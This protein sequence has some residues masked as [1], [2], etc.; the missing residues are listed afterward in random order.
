MVVGLSGGFSGT[1]GVNPKHRLLSYPSTHKCYRSAGP[2]LLLDYFTGVIMGGQVCSLSGYLTR[3]QD[4][5]F[6]VVTDDYLK[7]GTPAFAGGR[8]PVPRIYQRG[9]RQIPHSLTPGV[10]QSNRRIEEENRF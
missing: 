9:K 2:W 6:L 1:V 3:S 10:E 8:Y 5:G 7:I 4:M